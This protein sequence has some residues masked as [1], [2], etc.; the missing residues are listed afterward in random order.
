M[1]AELLHTGLVLIRSSAPL[2]AVK[3]EQGSCVTELHWMATAYVD[4]QG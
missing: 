1:P 4:G 3:P 2:A